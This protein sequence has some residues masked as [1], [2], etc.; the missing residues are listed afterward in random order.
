MASSWG[1]SWGTS[2]GNSWGAIAP[3]V[4]VSGGFRG[5][6]RRREERE[7]AKKLLI[8]GEQRYGPH[9]DYGLD[10]LDIPKPE[11]KAKRK[12]IILTSFQDLATQEIDLSQFGK[13]SAQIQGLLDDAAAQESFRAKQLELLQTQEDEEL[14]M[15]M[16]LAS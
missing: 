7:E 13:T 1:L 10:S 4:T 15:L 12:P 16:M 14:L 5:K 8:R 2:W 6:K 11:K 3:V 9:N